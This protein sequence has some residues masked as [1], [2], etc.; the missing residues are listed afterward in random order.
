MRLAVLGASLVERFRNVGKLAKATSD[1]PDH[2]HLLLPTAAIRNWDDLD[3]FIELLRLLSA[4]RR[5]AFMS[6]AEL[7]EGMQVIVFRPLFD[8]S[9]GLTNAAFARLTEIEDECAELGLSVLGAHAASA[10]LI[11][12]GEYE[13]NLDGMLAEADR[14]RK[15][16]ATDAIALS[17]IDAM[18]GQQLYLN[19][20]PIDGLRLLSKGLADPSHIVGLERASRL[21]DALSAA[22]DADE[23][24]G[25]FTDQLAALLRDEEFHTPEGLCQMHSQ[26]ALVRWRQKRRH[27]AFGHL[28]KGVVHF[29]ELEDSS[30][31]RQLGTGLAH[32]IHYCVSIAE[33]GAP[34]PTASD[35]GPYAE[36]RPQMFSGA[37]Q[38]MAGMW[39]VRQGPAMLQWVLGRLATALGLHNA[40]SSWTDRALD[41]ATESKSAVLLTLLIPRATA[42]S[43]RAS[44]WASAIDAAITH[45]RARVFL[46]ELHQRGSS[47]VDESASFDPFDLP[48]DEATAQKAEKYSLWLLSLLIV[49]ELCARVFDADDSSRA[50]LNSL[51]G[52]LAEF[53]ARSHLPSA[54][55]AMADAVRLSASDRMLDQQHKDLLA[56]SNETG[57]NSARFVAHGLLALRSDVRFGQAV[58]SQ[59]GAL[60]ELSVESKALEIPPD[61]YARTI[62]KFWEDVSSRAPFRF[63]LPRE[64]AKTIATAP[65]LPPLPRSKAIL[66]A[67]LYALPAKA[68]AESRDWLGQTS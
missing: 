39:K 21:V 63:A 25:P 35:G 51:S 48:H 55:Q 68:S 41:A 26:I 19:K 10:K 60:Q 57:S 9:G 5:N 6:T 58:I 64:L 45:G 65:I 4:E 66:R 22:W 62:S 20:R 1:F 53:A 56:E 16:F 59:I 33:S 13:K 17:V 42:A 12:L 29:L 47:V 23:D 27:E 3:A 49:N 50:D 46:E 18:T 7:K 31:A 28:E 34:P 40:A 38:G 67:V 37:N 43:L 11:V 44:A 61:T 14:A 52:A 24:A 32:V 15:R 36:G 30:R 54:W 8:A 2:V